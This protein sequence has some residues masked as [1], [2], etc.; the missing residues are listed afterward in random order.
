MR[1]SNCRATSEEMAA[2]ADLEANPPSLD[3]LAGEPVTAVLNRAPGNQAG[4]GG[5]K[6]TTENGWFAV[7]PSC[8]EPVYKIY[9]KVCEGLNT[10]RRFQGRGTAAVKW[11]AQ[12]LNHAHRSQVLTGILPSGSSKS[13]LASSTRLAKSSSDGR[14]WRESS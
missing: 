14:G 11:L 2:F 3:S 6:V 12:G 5:I 9:A 1:A 7:R 8:T 13:S 4:F 10:L